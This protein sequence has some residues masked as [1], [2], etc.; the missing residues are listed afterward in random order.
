MFKKLVCLAVS[1]LAVGS[2]AFMPSLPMVKISSSAAARVYQPAQSETGLRVPVSTDVMVSVGDGENIDNAVKR[3]KREVNKSG[4]LL[5][6]RFHRYHET[7]QEKAKRKA[8]QARRKAR[9]LRLS[10]RKGQKL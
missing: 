9:M 5:D 10:L 7:N 3:F 8:V 2:Q 6:L 4:H 1:T